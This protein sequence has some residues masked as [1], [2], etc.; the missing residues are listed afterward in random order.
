MNLCLDLAIKGKGKV[1]PNPLVGCVLVKNN[2]VIGKGYHKKF[3]NAHAEVNAINDALN[4]TNNI[5]G[6]SLYVNLEPC[7]HFGKTPPCTDLIIKHKIRR[8]VIGMKDPN[9]L[10]NG[11]GISKL[12][13]SGIIVDSGILSEKCTELNDK[14]IINVT[15][16][17]PYITLKVAQSIDGIIA[18]NNFKSKWITDNESREFAH[19]LRADN[20]CILI[21]QNSIVHDNPELTVRLVKSSKSPV[22]ILIDKDLKLTSKYKLLQ[23]KSPLTIVFHSSERTTRDQTH[24][25]YIKVKNIKGIIQMKE[26]AKRLYK[27]GYNSL[28]VEGG[29]FVYS[30]FI[31]ENL[32]DEVNVIIAPKIIGEGISS[33]K[34]FKID[35]IAKSKELFLMEISLLNKD[36]VL[37][38]KNYN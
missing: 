32:F 37:K 26:I 18:L 16:K 8:V 34:D 15:K 17:R 4:K 25:N 31:K 5:K 38:Y 9:H 21:G 13:E 12:K 1:E 10:V 27:M 3:G 23:N 19:E 2:T 36:I 24:L 29:A 28:L 20:D 35:R 33:F 6:S 22:R 30:Q 14:F 7:S 11:N